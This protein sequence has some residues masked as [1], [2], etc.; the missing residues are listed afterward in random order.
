METIRKC[1]KRIDRDQH[2]AF[3]ADILYLRNMSSIGKRHPEEHAI[4]QD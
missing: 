3:Q 1:L 4:T 2:A